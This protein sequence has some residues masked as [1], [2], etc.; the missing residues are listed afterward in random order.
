MNI[1]IVLIMLRLPL[2]RVTITKNVSK[3]VCTVQV[4][5]YIQTF[6]INLHYYKLSKS[7]NVSLIND[8]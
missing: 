6:L 7:L 2:H 3:Y 4:P 5:I 8:Q 1:F